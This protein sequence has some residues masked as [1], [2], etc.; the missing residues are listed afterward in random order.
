[1]LLI[2]RELLAAACV[3]TVLER[4]LAIFPSVAHAVARD[5]AESDAGLTLQRGP[6]DSPGSA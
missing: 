6:P 5:W 2:L 1:M 4:V 3:S